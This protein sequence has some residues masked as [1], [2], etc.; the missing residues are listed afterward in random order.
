MEKKRSRI[1]T[2]SDWVTE[3]DGLQDTSDTDIQ[4]LH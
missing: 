1:D 2:N 4:I 3:F